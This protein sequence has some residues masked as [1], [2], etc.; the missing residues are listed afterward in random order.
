[1]SNDIFNNKELLPNEE[2]IY[3]AFLKDSVNR[4]DL[5]FSFV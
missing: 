3:Q 4:V 5:V 1:M 2:N